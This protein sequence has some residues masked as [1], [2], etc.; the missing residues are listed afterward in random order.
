MSSSNFN[1]RF[2]L[3]SNQV[4]K[5]GTCAIMVRITVNSER[6][7]FSTK[8]FVDP[9]MWDKDANKASGT[10][11]QVKELNRTLEDIRA[12]I[13]Q[14]YYEI[15]R[16]DTLV[17]AELSLTLSKDLPLRK[18]SPRRKLQ[19]HGCSIRNRGLCQFLEAAVSIILKTTLLP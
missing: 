19:S 5:E 6:T 9:E 18:T 14:H 13:R 16:Y 15:E 11:K 1:I 10:S 8:L 17:T 12:S 2:Y 3:R 7:V 4:N